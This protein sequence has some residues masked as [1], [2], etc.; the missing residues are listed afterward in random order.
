MNLSIVEKQEVLE[1]IDRNTEELT[2]FIGPK[3]EHAHREDGF[4]E[5]TLV[6]SLIMSFVVSVGNIS[7]AVM[8]ID[9]LLKRAMGLIRWWKSRAK[10][11]KPEVP[12]PSLREKLL[13]ILFEAY[14]SNNKG[15]TSERLFFYCGVDKPK[16][17]AALF[18]MVAQGVVR[19]TRQGHW[20]YVRQ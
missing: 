10:D 20:K 14:A 12:E 15:V 11:D 7:K 3:A 8:S 17:E 18:E 16:L 19:K 9:D 2:D 6:V 13:V 1:F 5:I 4:L